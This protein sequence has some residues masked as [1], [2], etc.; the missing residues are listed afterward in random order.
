MADDLK[1]FGTTG[2]KRSG[3]RINE[4]WLKEL[5][6]RKFNKVIMEMRDQ[7][8]VIGA[9]LFAIEMLIRQVSWRVE[10]ASEDNK[11]LEAKEFL[12][13]NMQDMSTSGESLISEIL[14]FLTWGWAY[15][16]IVYKKRNGDSGDSST[17]SRFTDGKIGWRKIPIRSQESLI[18]WKY[19][20]DNSLEGMIQQILGKSNTLI[21]IKSN[22]YLGPH[23]TSKTQKVKAY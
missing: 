7:D 20:E 19:S 9:I 21:P 23:T 11:D 4:E 13:S 14:S 5:Q 12:E 3:G 17:N 22:C 16:E 6:G 10:P 2:L 15:H 18:E 1:E 8:A